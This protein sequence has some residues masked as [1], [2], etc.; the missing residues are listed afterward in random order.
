VYARGALL[1]HTVES[2][3]GR[4]A[5]R[6]ALADYVRTFSFHHPTS[7]DL[8]RALVSRAPASTRELVA[9]LLDRVLRA[10]QDLDYV[11]RC[12]ANEIEV[13]RRGALALPLELAVKS[14]RGEQLLVLDGKAKREHRRIPGLRRAQLGPPERLLLDPTPADHVC[15]LSLV[16]AR[17]ALGWATALQPILQ[18]LGP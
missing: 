11:V 3:V 18:V 13:E 1:L 10:G 16:P 4:Q 2:L 17:A 12:R 6:A 7:A 9:R 5:M 8:E 14:E 15:E